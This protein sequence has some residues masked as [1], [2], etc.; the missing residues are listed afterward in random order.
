MIW[1]GRYKLP[2]QERYR[3][4]IQSQLMI[5]L[6]YKTKIWKKSIEN[7]MRIWAPKKKTNSYK[8][9]NNYKESC[10]L[11]KAKTR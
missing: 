8:G 10:K 2:D 1:R 9:S 5:L 7:W 6:R 4:I 11:P 3:L